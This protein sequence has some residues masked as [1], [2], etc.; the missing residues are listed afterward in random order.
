MSPLIIYSCSPIMFL[1]LLLLLF[2]P[3]AGYSELDGLSTDFPRLSHMHCLICPVVLWV[4][5]HCVDW[6]SSILYP[7]TGMCSSSSTCTWRGPFLS[8]LVEMSE[9]TT[10]LHRMSHGHCWICQA[11]TPVTLHCVIRCSS[12]LWP[13]AFSFQRRGPPLSS[14][15][16]GPWTHY[17]IELAALWVT[18][19]LPG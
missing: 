13:L 6:S 12:T 3:L 15:L 2:E 16:V 14:V 4:P 5:L 11:N 7:C 10:D 1:M 18:H 8:C 19:V 9:L 17:C